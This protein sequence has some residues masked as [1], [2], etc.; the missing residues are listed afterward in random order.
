MS[1]STDNQ[2][3]RE[4]TPHPDPAVR[5]AIPG[6][7]MR[8]AK[9]PVKIFDILYLNDTHLTHKRL[10]ERKRLLKSGKI[11]K[12]I[13]DYQGRLEFAEEKRGKSGKDIRAMLE[14]IL[15]TK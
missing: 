6:Q 9:V 5:L 3:R 15:E 14:R 4:M 10:S 7:C 12:D 2:I 8:Q 13:E 11:F 1:P